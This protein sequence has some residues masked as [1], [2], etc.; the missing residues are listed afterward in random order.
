MY[1]LVA[2]DCDGTLLND[3]KEIS[4]YTIKTIKM[5]KDM[6][7]KIVIST[8]K[9]FSKIHRY[10]E[11]LE[12]IDDNQ[13]TIAFNGGY[14]LNNTEKNIL[15]ED[16]LSKETVK[17]IVKLSKMFDLYTFIYEKEKIISNQFCDDYI[18][19]NPDVPFFVSNFDNLDVASLGVHKIIIHG[20]NKEELKRARILL[21]QDCSHLCEITSSNDNNIELI[22]FGNSKTS[23]L[24]L[25]S[26]ELG[27]LPSE[28]IAF[29]DNENDIDMFNYVGYKVA[30]GNAIDK[31][32]D[33]SSRVTLSNNNDGI[34]IALQDMV[35]EGI[36]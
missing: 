6:G 32:K 19:K 33:I 12:L 21:E 22:P 35:K 1:K 10:L 11:E 34:A 23:G 30:M 8:S 4:E 16:L 20:P 3:Q 28:M 24:Q 14:I 17:K 9:S 5:I 25:L 15:H 13:Y 26:Q 2:L 27:I 36:I 7:I 29:G 18:L 31:L